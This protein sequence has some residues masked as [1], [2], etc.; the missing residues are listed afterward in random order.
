MF[1]SIEISFIKSSNQY[2]EKI[3]YY[4]EKLLNGF[5]DIIFKSSG[6]TGI[7]K[8]IKLEF[9]QIKISAENT[10]EYFQL[11]DNQNMLLC[12]N[13]DFIAG[14]MVLARA[15]RAK[16][17]LFVIEPSQNP[18]DNLPSNIVF[19][20]TSIVPTQLT[21]IDEKQLTLISRQFKNILIGGASISEK[22][23][24]KLLNAKI[25]AFES[26]GMT[27]TV[28]HIALKKIDEP[29]FTCLKNIDIDI[30]KESR[31]VIKSKYLS[32]N[33]II[34]N[35]V[36]ELFENNKFR[37]IGRYDNIINSG[38]IK[39]SLDEIEKIVSEILLENKHEL[40]FFI[41]KKSHST[42]GEIP[43]IIFQK[44]NFSIEDIVKKIVEKVNVHFNTNILSEKNFETRATFLLTPSFKIDRE[45]TYNQ[46]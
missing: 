14:F 12:L 5:D 23:K 36:V 4:Y 46:S 32:E 19:D 44:N 13:I 9:N 41:W 43:V 29:Y 25:N 28:S 6:S 33:E 2:R 15:M 21:N 30:D 17:K 1:N 11:S 37:Y 16:M 42:W 40:N 38:A 22:T 35:D 7:P 10:I 3:L 31:L 8:E 26:Y 45:K 39:I 27:E 24:K 34:T 20:F 18:F